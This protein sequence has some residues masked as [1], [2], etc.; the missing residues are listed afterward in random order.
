MYVGGWRSKSSISSAT[1]GRIATWRSQWRW[2][3][4][5]PFLPGNR[6]ESSLFSRMAFPLHPKTLYG[7]ARFAFGE[8]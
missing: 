8:I 6:R 2:R 3:I 1:E 7:S 4:A 5:A